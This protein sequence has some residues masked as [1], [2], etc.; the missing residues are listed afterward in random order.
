M[1][2]EVPWFESCRVRRRVFLNLRDENSSRIGFWFGK[3]A[4]SGGVI[5]GKPAPRRI[6]W[7]RFDNA[8]VVNDGPFAQFKFD[9]L[10]ALGEIPERNVNFTIG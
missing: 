9:S 5:D 4:A 1:G 6:P 7:F 8:F 10:F 2:N 3:S